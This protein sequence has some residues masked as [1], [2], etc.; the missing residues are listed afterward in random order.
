MCLY[1]HICLFNFYTACMCMHACVF[2]QMHVHMGARGEGQRTCPSCCPLC[3]L[4][5]SSPSLELPSLAVGQIS[6]ILLSLLPGPHP[7]I[8]LQAV[9]RGFSEL[10]L[11]LQ[12][13]LSRLSHLSLQPGGIFFL[14]SWLR[15][16]RR[17]DKLGEPSQKPQGSYIGF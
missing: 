9:L 14:T 13:V 4:R 6:G 3:L 1:V 17:S 7:S 16:I 15:C 5:Q 8:C 2:L 11:L 12:Q 10:L